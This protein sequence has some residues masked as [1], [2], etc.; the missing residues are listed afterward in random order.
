MTDDKEKTLPEPPDDMKTGYTN[1]ELYELL[2][3]NLYHSLNHIK[4][5]TEMSSE[6]ME[7]VQAALLSLTPGLDGL[8]KAITE[9]METQEFQNVLRLIRRI[10]R[11]QT[12][13]KV[14]QLMM[15]AGSP[16]IQEALEKELKKPQYKGKTLV[17]L[18]EDALDYGPI[19]DKLQLFEQ[20]VT[21]AQKAARI[22]LLPTL[23]SDGIPKYYVSPNTALSNALEAIDGK[24]ELIGAGPVDIPVLNVGSKNEV[25][26]Y[27]LAT[28]ENME[29]LTYSGK[30]FS[31][32]DRTVLDAVV[33]L[34]ADRTEKNMPA[35]ATA[36]IIYRIMTHKTE[37]EYVS[38]A[39]QKKVEAS[40]DKMRYNIRVKADATAELKARGIDTTPDGKKITSYT[41]DNFI[42][43]A[44]KHTVTAG[45]KKIAAYI[46]HEPILYNYAR[47]TGQ[48][49]TV[50]GKM[51]DIKQVDKTGRV[52]TTSLPNTDNRIAVKSYILRRVQI[53][54]H[55]EQKAA[56]AY[57]KYMNRR[58]KASELPIKN[59]SDFRKQQRTI[60][61]ST[62]FRAADI[63]TN[64]QTEMRKYVFDV[65]DFWAAMSDKKH[66]IKG[67]KKR[68]K[69]K[70]ADAVIIDV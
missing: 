28:L 55:D 2:G 64:S 38:P 24:G 37:S 7:Q 22:D 20:A 25:T 30:P 43:S 45:G 18:F 65:L 50:P 13:R 57:R 29:N 44:D 42:L 67:Y 3:K 61:F 6:L 48:L 63:K 5:A 11:L 21:E 23:E 66:G 39:Q 56:D 46:F 8:E 9:K 27:A 31:E 51:L 10:S 4:H 35:A 19:S 47:L 26:V 69:G 62:I 68:K 17:Q 1:D 41:I 32:Y 40:I 54:K 36:D 14:Y 58:K 60:L 70:T 15:D 59:I 34:Y 52:L 33:S 12:V 53:M 16:A 49:F